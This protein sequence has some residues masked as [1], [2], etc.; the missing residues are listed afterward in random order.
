MSLNNY[1]S[2]ISRC[3]KTDFS[4]GLGGGLATALPWLFPFCPGAIKSQPGATK[5]RFP[6]VVIPLREQAPDG[7]AAKRKCRTCVRHL[8]AFDCI[9]RRRRDSNPRSRFESAWRISSALPSTTRPLLQC[10]FSK[11]LVKMSDKIYF[12]KNFIN[13]APGF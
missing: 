10:K 13:F 11:I 2:T 5:G 6:S 9:A 7:N 4:D 1:I 12:L 3:S 8:T